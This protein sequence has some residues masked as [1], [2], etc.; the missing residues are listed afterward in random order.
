MARYLWATVNHE[1]AVEVGQRA[2]AIA[3]ELEDVA[4]QAVANYTVAFAYHDLAV[5]GPAIEILR[6]NLALLEGDLTRERLGQL[7]LPSVQ[8]RIALAWC[9]SWQ[10]AFPEAATLIQEATRIAE[11]VGHPGSVHLALQ[12]GGL[13]YLLK[14]DLDEA[15]P[16]LEGCLAM[17]NQTPLSPATLAFLAHAYTLAGRVADALPLFAQSLERAAAIKFLPC[18]ALWIG[19]WG[20]A[21]LLAGRFEDA[22]EHATRAHDIAQ[23][24]KE[25]G[26]E[27][28]ALR[29][30][31]SIAVHRHPPESE[32][33]EAH[34]RQALAL[35]GELGM[36]PL[37]AHCHLGLGTLY[38]RMGRVEQARVEL[39]AAIE[40]YRVMD[41]TFWLPQA[42]AALARVEQQ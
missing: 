19:W 38:G 2:C 40:L 7:F 12:G 24:Q 8:S 27:A 4:L 36:R 22:M 31:G 32:S 23:A 13:L 29:L 20:E 35:A 11:G 41:M 10:G 3:T 17:T 30:L 1:R 26:Y 28:Y 16:R 14:G 39:T 18:N 42:E 25:Q 34:Y 15:I 5:Y 9:L 33:A 6:H 21:A 37:L